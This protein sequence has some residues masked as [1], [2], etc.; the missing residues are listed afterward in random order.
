MFQALSSVAYKIL[1]YYY[2]FFH[3]RLEISENKDGKIMSPSFPG[4]QVGI[5]ETVSEEVFL[6]LH[7]NESSFGSLVHMIQGLN[8]C[9]CWVMSYILL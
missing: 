6:I 5:L 3:K 1:N 2:D 9:V 4:P 8:I 7:K